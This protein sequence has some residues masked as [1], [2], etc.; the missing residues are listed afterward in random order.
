MHFVSAV[1]QKMLGTRTCVHQGGNC[2]ER[3]DERFEVEVPSTAVMD[4]SGVSAG[5]SVSMVVVMPADNSPPARRA[6]ALSRS[7]GP[8]T[9]VSLASLS[10]R[11]LA[12]WICARNRLL[13]LELGARMLST[14]M[15]ASRFTQEPPRT[16][17]FAL[18]L[19]C[20]TRNFIRTKLGT[21][22]F[23]DARAMRDSSGNPCVGLAGSDV[24]FAVAAQVTVP[25]GTVIFP[26]GEAASPTTSTVVSF[27]EP[28]Q[29]AGGNASFRVA[30]WGRAE[31]LCGKNTVI[32]KCLQIG[33]NDCPSAGLDKLRAYMKGNFGFI[34]ATNCLL[35]DIREV[36]AN[37]RRGK[38]PDT[39]PVSIWCC[40][41]DPSQTSFFQLLSIRTKMVGPGAPEIVLDLATVALVDGASV[42][43][44]SVTLQEVGTFRLAF[45]TDAF[46]L[47]P[48]ALV[49]P[50]IFNVV[51][52]DSE[53]PIE[54]LLF[55]DVGFTSDVS[56]DI[57][58]YFN[59]RIVASTDGVE[60]A[61]LY[62]HSDRVRVLHLDPV[63]PWI[64]QPI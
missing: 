42:F 35:D 3:T 23:I 32:P 62:G 64:R 46:T 1:G 55:P 31:V 15:T 36:L 11:G 6:E 47:S 24:N 21:F 12:H 52:P 25:N 13:H 5:T 28:V 20:W 10:S 58:F 17:R 34:L 54:D 18:R 39:S 57:A 30:L 29:L 14:R 56:S 45:D 9:S 2:R 43:I 8:T 27:A 40:L 60:V 59:E 51:P 53:E 41:Q 44:F 16:F 63:C 33:H 37:N 26:A 38:E 7:N 50:A 4:M 48:A 61:I 19:S 22:F 49:S